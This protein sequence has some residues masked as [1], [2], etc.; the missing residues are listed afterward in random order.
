M[1]FAKTRQ[2]LTL[3]SLLAA[4]AA[5]GQ[6]APP[7]NPREMTPEERQAALETRREAFENMTEEER[8][9]ALEERGQ[10]GQERRNAARE[11]FENMSE[12]ERQAMRERRQ[13]EGGVRQRGSQG[14]RAD[15]GAGHGGVGRGGMGMGA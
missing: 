12:E 6:D 1:Q 5:V 10:L 7:G 14:G 13:Q 3:A 8:A 11:R 4:G 9:A 2:I 15:P